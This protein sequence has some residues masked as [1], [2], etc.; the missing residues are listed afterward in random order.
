M[1][2]IG[3]VIFQ[4]RHISI[5][6]RSMDF[7]PSNVKCKNKMLSGIMKTVIKMGQFMRQKKKE[8]Q[9]YPFTKLLKI[10]SVSNIGKFDSGTVLKN[11]TSHE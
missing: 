4:R 3:L 2:G 1:E 5:L 6:L 7:Y 8:L 9:N 10:L 11:A